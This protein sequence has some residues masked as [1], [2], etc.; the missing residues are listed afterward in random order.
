[1]KFS[2]FL[3]QSAEDLLEKYKLSASISSWETKLLKDLLMLRDAEILA[4][5][6]MDL[7]QHATSDTLPPENEPITLI[8]NRLNDEETK[9]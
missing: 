1:M 2:Q 3:E 9:D 7:N 5:C 6:H 4:K 8:D